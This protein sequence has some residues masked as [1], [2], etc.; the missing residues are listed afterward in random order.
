MLK[1][2][3]I[4][5]TKSETIFTKHHVDIGLILD[6]Q[7]IKYK[8]PWKRISFWKYSPYKGRFPQLGR[9][10]SFIIE[11]QGQISSWAGHVPSRDF[12]KGRND[13]KLY[14][15]S[16]HSRCPLYFPIKWLKDRTQILNYQ[17][18]ILFSYP[19]NTTKIALGAGVGRWKMQDKMIL[20]YLGKDKS[21]SL[22]TSK[23][24]GYV[25]A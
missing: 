23:D 11:W 15:L 14:I 10:A 2:N 13:W 12:I 4:T 20:V 7:S 18:L 21:R 17:H 8:V 16:E 9:L 19:K 5:W 25:K 1:F 6:K 24:N 3:K 22:Y